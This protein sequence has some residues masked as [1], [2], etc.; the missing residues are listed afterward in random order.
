MGKK[1]IIAET[2]AGQHGVAVA[3]VCALM[4][5]KCE[6]FMGATDIERQE[7]NV[8]KMRMLGAT[9]RAVTEGNQTL[10]EACDAAIREWCEYP[11]DTYYLIG[12]AVGPHPYPDIVARLQSIISAEIKEQ[13]ACSRSLQGHHH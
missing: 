11:H 13:C 3:T 6:I 12:S 4:G 5:M 7:I 8:K 10:T 1:R 2:G 9:V